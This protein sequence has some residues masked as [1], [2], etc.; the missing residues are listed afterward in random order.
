MSDISNRLWDKAA[1]LKIPLTGA[2]E[3]TPVCNLKCRMCYVRKSVREVEQ[4]GGLIPAEQWL[5][6]ARQACN[7]GMLKPLLTG[8]EPFMRQDIREI[9]SGMQ[10][11]G[12]QVSINTNGTLIDKDM[13]R[14]LSLNCPTRINITLYGGTND[15]YQKL[16]GNGEAF[17]HVCRTVEWLKSYRIPVKFNTSITPENVI[18]LEQIISYAK[19]VESPIQVATYM[20]PPVRRDET[21]IGS[22]NRLSPD[23]AARAC[24]K[25]DLLQ[26]NSKWFLGM[27][28]QYKFWVPVTDELIKKWNKGQPKEMLCRAGRCSFWIDWQ[29]N[30]AN[31]GMYPSVKIPLGENSFANG[32]EQIVERTSHVRYSSVCANCPNQRLCH[33]CIAMVYNECGDINGRPEYLCQMNQASAKY[34]Q[35]CA[36]AIEEGKDPLNILMDRKEHD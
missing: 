34:Y 14:W 29:G 19:S 28:E 35:L 1:R 13:A 33:P 3:L 16:C 9:L 26:N 11:M 25:A 18:D 15:S 17:D 22:N 24:V 27:A 8:G 2:F 30:I 32:W 12:L 31:C 5:E 21:M 20:F 7:A 10:N 4:S 6:W 36:Q 23:E